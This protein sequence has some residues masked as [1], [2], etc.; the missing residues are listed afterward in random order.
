MSTKY[1]ERK[2]YYPTFS[3]ALWLLVAAL[4]LSIALSLFLRLLNSWFNWPPIHHP[5]ITGIVNSL[6][7]AILLWW[8]LKRTQTSA[9]KLFPFGAVPLYFSVYYI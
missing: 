5:T 9:A 1:V 6:V 3:Q 7:I 8:G 2:Q 4:A